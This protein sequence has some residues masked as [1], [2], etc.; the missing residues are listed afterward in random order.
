MKITVTKIVGKSTLVSEVEG[1]KE[2]DALVRASL[3]TSMPDKCGLCNSE[4]VQLISNKAGTYSYAK[5]RCMKCTATSTM[6]Q[7][8]D[9]V[10]GFWKDFEIYK[11][12]AK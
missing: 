8:Q 9:G 1:D 7:Y 10:S 12:P 11:K 3:C 5:I 4:D 2:L 6:G